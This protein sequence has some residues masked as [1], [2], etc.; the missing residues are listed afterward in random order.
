VKPND[1]TT[2]VHLVGFLTGIVL[3]A[4]LGVMTLRTR[5][6]RPVRGRTSGAD[7]IPLAT[8]SFGLVWNCGALAIYGFR[9]FGFGEARPVL[10][11]LAFSALG[12]S[13]PSLSTPRCS[14]S[15]SFAVHAR[16]WAP[17]TR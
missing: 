17:H 15:G 1:L 10:T 7:R 11:A 6:G 9:D 8:A 2:L 16:S 3:Y 12:F 14:R 5:A 13:L 4:M